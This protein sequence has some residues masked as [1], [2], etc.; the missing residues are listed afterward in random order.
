MRISTK[1]RYG[2]RT[3]MDVAIHQVNGPV[4][5]N[6][7]AERQAISVKYLWQ[8]INP[9]KTAGYLNALRGAKGGYMLA[10]RPEDI[11]MLDVVTTLE[12]P[13]SI[14]ECLTNKKACNRINACIA[15]TV[16]QEANRAIEKALGAITLAEVLHRCAV[17]S[18]VENYMI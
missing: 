9:L 6:D 2:L 4:T 1:G 8:V 14:V 16:W 17:S 10:R 12:G 7:I 13:M 5:L 18:E 3:L 11:T 15:R